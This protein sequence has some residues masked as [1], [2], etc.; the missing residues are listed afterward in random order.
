MKNPT[1]RPSIRSRKTLIAVD[2][3]RNKLIYLMVVPMVVYL[4]VFCYYPMYG[5]VIAFKTYVPARG[6]LGSPWVG[7][8][9]FKDF[10][11]SFYFGRLIKN[12]FLISFWG[13]IFG[14]PAPILLA[15]M[16]NEI[17]GRAFK[18]IT[19]TVSYLPYF[20]SLIVICGLIRDFCSESGLIGQIAVQMG[21]VPGSLLSR[22]EN[23]YAIYTASGIWQGIGWGS[24]IYLAAIAG[25]DMELYDAAIIDG[26]G[27]FRQILHITIPCILPTVIILFLLN[28]GNILNVGFE[29]IILLYSP[30]IYSTAD[31]ISTFT[32]R[33][34]LI[35]N[36]FSYSTAVGLFNSAINFVFLVAAN[37]VSRRVSETSLW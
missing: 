6:I 5:A 28:I 12:T 13:I 14:F 32:Y 7:L 17:R 20:V 18:K 36:N 34:G 10:F 37:T 4:L 29:K 3:R 8:K 24:I 19:Q 30:A 15:L 27:R 31:V 16:L 9:H 11:G 35:E 33:R 26:A 2:F 23:F 22:P 1:A 21:G 25:I